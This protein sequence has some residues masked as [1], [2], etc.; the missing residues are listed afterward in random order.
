[1][2]KISLYQEMLLEAMKRRI[3]AAADEQNALRN[4]F[5]AKINFIWN[6][7]ANRE[8]LINGRKCIPSKIKWYE[9]HYNDGN[10]Y[11]LNISF[12]V[13]PSYLREHYNLTKTERSHINRYEQEVFNKYSFN[14]NACNE[15]E[16]LMDKVYRDFHWELYNCRNNIL[17][18]E[19]KEWSWDLDGITSAFFV[20]NGLCMNS[21]SLW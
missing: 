3:N 15:N 13:V 16:L 6:K 4:L 21:K 5:N 10:P 17:L 20:T 11:V 12:L 8:F 7:I 9:S 2:D 19:S 14:S 1:M 18:T